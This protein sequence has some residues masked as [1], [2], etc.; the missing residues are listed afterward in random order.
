[1]F[2]IVCFSGLNEFR[3]TSKKLPN[4]RSSLFVPQK[5]KIQN[6][7]YRRL[8]KVVNF[9]RPKTFAAVSWKKE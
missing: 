3:W 6:M 7:L 5:G 9:A 2:E 8:G 1:L 4:F